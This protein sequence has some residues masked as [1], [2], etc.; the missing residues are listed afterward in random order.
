M[1]NEDK[2]LRALVSLLLIFL[3]CLDIVAV[4]MIIDILQ[5]SVLTTIPLL[6]VIVA[7]TVSLNVAL[8]VMLI[9]TKNEWK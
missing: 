8:I 2:I 6:I 5:Y 1:T 7:F 3:V 4:I 9:E